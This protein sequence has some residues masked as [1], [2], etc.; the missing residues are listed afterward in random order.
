MATTQAPIATVSPIPH[1]TVKPMQAP[2]TTPYSTKKPDPSPTIPE[3]PQTILLLIIATI[4]LMVTLGLVAYRRCNSSTFTSYFRQW[5]IFFSYELDNFAC[6][7]KA[8]ALT[9][10]PKCFYPSGLDKNPKKGKYH[11]FLLLPKTEKK[12]RGFEWR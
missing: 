9:Y 8:N 3:L 4:F 11:C 12:Y 2:T 10:S 5:K 1:V 6:V 7:R